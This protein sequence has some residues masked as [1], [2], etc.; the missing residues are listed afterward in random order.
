MEDTKVSNLR[1]LLKTGLVMAAMTA[2]VGA[3][4]QSGSNITGPSSSDSTPASSLT[5]SGS[6]TN[7]SRTS[8]STDLY[9]R[10]ASIDAGNRTMQITGHSATVNVDA[11]AEVVYKA[12][13]NETPIALSA[14]AV[15]DSIEVRGFFSGSANF[16][17]DRVRKRPLGNGVGEIEFGGRVVSIDATARTF[18]LTGHPELITVEINAIIVKRSSGNEVSITLDQIKPNDSVDIR[19]AA[20]AGGILANRVRVRGPHAKD[21]TVSSVPTTQFKGAMALVGKNDSQFF[22][23]A[24]IQTGRVSP[25]AELNV[26]VSRIDSKSGIAQS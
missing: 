19:G 8:S 13:G 6:G 18:T 20:Q 16:N 14:I 15:G 21:S 7:D 17:A 10:V 1:N 11:N 4:S 25:M 12:N 2:V 9:G 3:C 23:N 22:A 24:E 5:G 26:I